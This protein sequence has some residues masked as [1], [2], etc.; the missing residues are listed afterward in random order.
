MEN[1][2]SVKNSACYYFDDMIKDIDIN[3]IDIS[4]HKKL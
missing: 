1:K 4:L 3:F 2:I